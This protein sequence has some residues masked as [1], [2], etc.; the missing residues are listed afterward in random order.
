MAVQDYKAVLMEKRNVAGSFSGNALKSSHVVG[1]VVEDCFRMVFKPAG[2]ALPVPMS[3]LKPALFESARFSDVLVH[4]R[5]KPSSELVK[6][7]PQDAALAVAIAKRVHEDLAS[8]PSRLCILT[9]CHMG[10]GGLEHDL[11]AEAGASSSLDRGMYSVELKCAE[12]MSKNPK[13]FSWR[14]VMQERALT[15]WRE[16]VIASPPGVWAGRLLVFVAIPRPS[17][18]EGPKF[19]THCSIV[20]PLSRSFDRVWG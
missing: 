19:S 17:C 18:R 11:I 13:G 20:K 8:A 15:K 10:P 14:S 4:G 1:K 9:A 12:I 6:V 5:R 7:Y 16:E 3:S 2:G